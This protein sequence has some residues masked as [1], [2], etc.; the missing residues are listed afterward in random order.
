MSS[1]EYHEQLWQAVPIGATPPGL[2]L[3]R[4]FLLDALRV[5][6]DRADGHD[7]DSDS[8]SSGDSARDSGSDGAGD[9][10]R[11]S[12]GNSAGNSAN[13]SGSDARRSLRVLDVGCGE[14]QLT[15]AVA[16]AGF[17]VIGVDVAEEPLRR[18]RALHADIDVRRIPAEAGWPLADASFD[19]VWAGE[20]IEHV[21]DTAGWL[22]EL[23]RV[24]RSG[25]SLLLSTPAHERL[26]LLRIALSGE[27][28]DR[29]FDPRSDHVRFYTRRTLARLLSD[30]GFEQVELRAAGG[31]PGA[32]RTLLAAAVR[33]RF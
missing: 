21:T 25:G 29:H 14:G 31:L 16:Q 7:S 17:T 10:G 15:A 18:A 19:V 13:A 4:A 6:A 5:A 32:R 3:R 12:A 30:F 22:S 24:L 26:A 23:R 11:D 8:P 1:S 33:S 28:F 20:T 9:S 2:E 27:R